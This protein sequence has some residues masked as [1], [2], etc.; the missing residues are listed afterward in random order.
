MRRDINVSFKDDSEEDQLYDR[1]IK[2]CKTTFLG[3]S[4]WMKLAA[5]EKLERDH[6]SSKS[7]NKPQKINMNNNQSGIINSLDDLFQK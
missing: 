4:G 6:G 7:D 2:E 3:Q 5:R 1:I